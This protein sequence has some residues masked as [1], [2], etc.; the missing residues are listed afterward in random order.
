MG[1]LYDVL[2][3]NRLS[4]ATQIEQGYRTALENL[5]GGDAHAEQDMIRAREIKEAYAILSSPARR[6][7]YDA[8][9]KVREQ[10]TIQVIEAPRNRWPAIGLIVLA[11][12]AGL[13]YT[14]HNS[15]KLEI[16]RVAL[17]A[18]KAK[19]AADAAALVAQAEEARLEQAKL[20]EK[21]RAD[22]IRSREV[23]LARYEGQR[24][25]EQEQAA[26]Y[27]ADR[28]RQ[29]AERQQESAT[30]RAKYEQA[31]EERAAQMRNYQREM[32]M[33]RALAIPIVRH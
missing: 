28:R 24:I 30:R 33:R 4:N 18:A 16:E 27:Q 23:E 32:D 2:G 11:L 15:K 12:V 26:E 9:L 6:D 17:E 31:Q 25:R 20:S 21:S 3:L 10:A 29:F 19:N 13:A 22:A 1:T 14:N 7:A 8:Q 5:C